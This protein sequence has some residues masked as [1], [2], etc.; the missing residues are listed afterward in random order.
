MGCELL[1]VNV[2][3]AGEFIVRQQISSDM[4]QTLETNP[5]H[6]PLFF[7]PG[8]RFLSPLRAWD[9]PQP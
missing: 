9:P 3:I 4:T 8:T 1:P 7:L 2:R 6:K 5:W